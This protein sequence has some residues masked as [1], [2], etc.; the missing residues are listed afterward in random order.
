MRGRRSRPYWSESCG[1]HLGTIIDTS[2]T[3]HLGKSAMVEPCS[4]GSARIPSTR[5]TLHR[6]EDPAAVIRYTRGKSMASCVDAGWCTPLASVV[7]ASGFLQAASWRPH[8]LIRALRSPCVSQ[9]C[10]ADKSAFSPCHLLRTLNSAVGC[11]HG[12]YR[13]PCGRTVHR[14]GETWLGVRKSAE[15][16]SRFRSIR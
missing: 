14:R 10:S 6:A 15:M 16:P 9:R 13:P 3:G 5:H 12:L 7:Q 11:T 2:T 4:Q 1:A 8:P